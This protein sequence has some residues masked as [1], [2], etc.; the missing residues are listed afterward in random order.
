MSKENTIDFNEDLR[1]SYLT[2]AMSVIT[3]RALPDVRD[4]LKPVH[5]RILY[6]MD[7][8]KLHADKDRF[9]KAARVVGDTMG[10]FHPHGNTAIY[11]A[12]VIMSQPWKT[13]A[14][15]V[16]FQGNNGSID[17]DKAAAERYPEVK[18]SNFAELMLRGIRKDTVDFIPNFAEEV[19]DEEP[20]VLPAA[21]PNLLV[22]GTF[23][24][25]VGMASSIPP[26]NF[27]EALRAVIAFLENQDITVEELVEKYI[28][29]PDFPLGGTVINKREMLECYKTGKGK[30][31][32]RADYTVN[33]KK[34]VITFNNIPYG[35]TKSAVFQK[36]LEGFHNNLFTNVTKVED[37]SGENVMV[38]LD[39][40]Y[41][42]GANVENILKEVYLNTPLQSNFSFN[43]HALVDGE[44]ARLGL[45]DI[46]Y[47][48]SKHLV[49]THKREINYDLSKL[50]SRLHILY[51]YKIIL[52]DIDN[53]I[54]LIKSSKNPSS[55]V[56]ALMTAYN[57]TDIQAKAVVELKLGRITSLEIEKVIKEIEEK[58]VE[59]V[60]LESLLADKNL[61]REYVVKDINNTIAIA[62]APERRTKL[63]DVQVL[64]KAKAKAVKEDVF[65]PSEETYV[66]LDSTNALK[67]C[68]KA[69]S[70]AKIKTCIKT[71]TSDYIL[72]FT[73]QGSVTKMLV[74]DIPKVANA[75]GLGQ[76]PEFVLDEDL[77]IYVS[78][79]DNDFIVHV[80]KNNLIKKSAMSEFKT[81]TK[82]NVKA[83]NLSDDNEI[84]SIISVKKDDS[85]MC[86]NSLGNALRFMESDINPTG[87]VTKGVK[88]MAEGAI[89]GGKVVVPTDEALNKLKI[90]TRG[91]K[92]KPYTK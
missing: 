49:T 51:G 73:K 18:K 35:E 59:V 34:R 78:T 68:D 62:K 20:L 86:L 81:I 45:K 32:I 48:Y 19:G 71:N 12:M 83:I 64:S 10:R 4:G 43:M 13:N 80:T 65:I 50:K 15:L 56:E 40:F 92:G 87:R 53:V 5:R 63:D 44:P 91:K 17:G 37:N 11:D 26:H 9:K 23:G 38:K 66:C 58:E 89:L 60:R 3:D 79:L 1:N 39:I 61:L 82:Q 46:I 76:I 8:L 72:V 77:I 24:I 90:E 27:N 30:A 21:Y 54:S 85:I 16:E 75:T 14:L 6:A 22:N 74:N 67:R 7:E 29:A 69:L 55:A 70:G 28:P 84:V 41:K 25:A 52:E 88:C 31:V 33:E 36:L 47:H 42:E 2:Y 57:L